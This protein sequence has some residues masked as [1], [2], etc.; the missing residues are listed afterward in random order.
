MSSDDPVNDLTSSQAGAFGELVVSADL[1]R[2]GC[3]VFRAVG[4]QSPC[5]LVLLVG[6]TA[7]RVEVTKGKRLVR[8]G[9]LGEGTRHA[10][11]KYDVLALWSVDGAVEYQTDIEWLQ[12]RLEAR[13]RAQAAGRPCGRRKHD[14]AS[15]GL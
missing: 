6:S 14:I 3:H 8:S 4:P 5:D 10:A 1:L 7:V 13:P 9:L 15:V 12:A 2:R 11:H